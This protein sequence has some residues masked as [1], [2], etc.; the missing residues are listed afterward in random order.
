[1]LDRF[2]HHG[3][4]V[5]FERLVMLHGPMVLALCRRL[6]RHEQDAEDA[7][8]G[9]FLTMARKASTIG[10]KEALASWLYKVAYRVACR[11][12]R[13]APHQTNRMAILDVT[14]AKCESDALS[15]DLRGVLDTEIAG[16]PESYRRPIVLCYLQ[17]KTNEEAA[18][19]LGCPRS[20]VAT[21]LAR[22]KELL[23]RRLT[24][25]GCTLSVATLT[26]ALTDKT[27][28]AP[29]PPALVASTLAYVS[30]KSAN[31]G[32][33]AAKVI[34]L[35]DGVLH[36]MWL[37]KMKMA[38]GVVLAVVVTG[39]GIGLVVS[40]TWAGG[41]E[42]RVAGEPAGRA[43]KSAAKADAQEG[44]KAEIEGLKKQ[45]ADLRVQLKAALK[46]IQ[47]L[48]APPERDAE[49]KALLKERYETLTEAADL[50]RNLFREGNVKFETLG[51]TQ[52]D[53]LEANLDQYD[54]PKERV[55][56]LRKHMEAVTQTY[57]MA[58]AQF[59]TG[60]VNKVTLDQAKAMVLGARIA[61][62]REENKASSKKSG[63]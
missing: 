45:V 55:A 51:A 38:V 36:M 6:L 23:R 58:N 33:L 15:H 31:T 28:A 61:L 3:D 30:G 37:N 8:Q 29:L 18:R 7:F 9:T 14:T 27:L 21:R 59:Q 39:A 22:A 19:L 62:L 56:A 41:G 10:N 60:Q 25:R 46:E 43:Q 50:L 34:A 32:A 35:S 42:G 1:L 48:T 52:R 53:A 26:T 63:D 57:Q 54:S 40:E 20:T 5:A 4:E 13:G 47:R 17:G 49:I 12:S 16:L 11:A 24:R 2:A 44:T